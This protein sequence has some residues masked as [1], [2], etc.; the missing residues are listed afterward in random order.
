MGAMALR[1]SG[2]WTL[3]ELKRLWDDESLTAA[4]L[5]RYHVDVAINRG[6]G[7]KL[8]TLKEQPV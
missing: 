8:G 6:L 1:Q 3:D 7:S 4:V 2:Q 5:P